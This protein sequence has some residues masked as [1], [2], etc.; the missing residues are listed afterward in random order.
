MMKTYERKITKEQYDKVISHNP[1]G[2]VLGID[3]QMFFTDV[4]LI[5]YGVY[6]ARVYESKGEYILSF[7]MGD[8]CD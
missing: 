3:E 4:Q 7:E 8:S 2:W 1:N 6:M 5:G